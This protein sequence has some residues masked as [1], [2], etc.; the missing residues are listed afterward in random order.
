MKKQLHWGI[1][2]LA[3]VLCFATAFAVSAAD[4]TLTY[5]F[6]GEPGE[7]DPATAYDARS[8]VIIQNCYDR[9]VT[10]SGTDA[11]VIAPQLAESW[12]I[13][14]DG[15]VYTFNLRQDATFHNG[16]P[17]TADAVKYSFDRVLTMNQPPAWMLS[18]MMDLDSTQVIDDYTVQINL[19]TPYAAALGVLTHTVASIVNPT[20]VEANGGIEADQENLFMNQNEAGAGSG[21]YILEQ[22]IPAEKLVFERNDGYWGTVGTIKTIEAP[23]V[24]EMAT[25]IMLLGAGDA[26]I[27]PYFPAVNVPDVDGL[28]GLVIES[29][30]TFDVN[31]I[32]LGCRGATADKAVRQA[33]S[34]AFPYQSVVDDVYLGY[35]TPL[36]GAVPAGMY[37]YYEIPAADKYTLNIDLANQILDDAG[38]AWPSDPGVGTRLNADNVLLDMEVL[39]PIGDEV[40]L[41]TALLWQDELKKIGFDLIIREIVW[42]VAYKVVRDHESDGM[43]TG[44]LPDYPDPDN[45]VDAILG[46][47]NSDAIYGSSYNNPDMDALILQ[48]K[49]EVDPVVRADLY[50]QI[51]E[52]T[53]DDAPYIWTAQAANVVVMNER[54]KGYYY[55]PALQIDFA[56]IYFGD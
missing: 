35:A 46:A 31:F 1:L 11:T 12:D 41:Q 8:S 28:P 33:I 52:L 40:R 30:P 38:W 50:K 54:V 43:L 5:L 44:W 56:A 26:D 15:L 7:A 6:Y 2:V 29:F 49:T 20:V 27:H 25:R 37:G 13:S 16:D 36:T 39:L 51:Q 55:N 34:Y 53:V 45:Y 21:P 3:S 19:T 47:D 4:D 17:V 14:S 23:I 9:L 42:A 18:Q 22:W 48:A 32:A 24:L 10:Y